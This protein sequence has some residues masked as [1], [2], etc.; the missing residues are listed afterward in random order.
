MRLFPKDVSLA[1]LRIT[2]L[3]AGACT[4][5]CGGGGTGPVA[6]PPPPPPSISVTVSPGTASVLL[7]LTQ[8]FTASVSGTTNTAVTWSVNNVP[9]GG[10]ATGTINSQGLYVAPPSVPAPAT[11]AVSATSQADTT[12]SASAQTT[13]HSDISVTVAPPVSNVELGA[14]QKFTASVS[15]AGQPDV[16]VRWSLSGAS[17]PASC[18]SIDSSGTYTAPQNLPNPSEISIVA[19]SAADPSKQSSAIVHFTSTFTLTLSGPAN[20]LTGGSAQITAT[21]IPVPGSSPNPA[22]TWDLSGAGCSG[23]ACGTLSPSGSSSSSGGTFSTSASYIAP[24]IAPNPASVTITA[25]SA[26]DSSKRA[27]LTIS[28]SQVISVT[29]SPSSA[30]RAANHRLTLFV[31]VTGS[32]NISVAWSVNGVPGGNASVGQICAVGSSPCQSITTSSVSQVDYLAPG[33]IPL[34]NPVMVQAVSQAAPA[35]IGF[36]QITVISHIVVSVTPSAVTLPPS[37]TQPFAAAV[38]GTDDQNAIWQIQ[39]P[40]CAN[41]PCGSVDASGLYAAPLAAPSPNSIQV[42]ATSSEDTSQTGSASVAIAGG[43]N[44]SNLLPASVFA[45][46]ASGFTLKVEGSGFTP[47]SPGPGSTLLIGNAARTTTCSSSS[48]C[49]AP[50]NASDV[51]TA[52]TLS[53]QARNP[54]NSTSN[55]VSLVI[56]APFASDETIS[57][58]SSSPSATD[59]DILVVQPTTAGVSTPGASVDLDVAALGPFSASTNSCTLAGNPVVLARPSSG[60][61]TADLCVFSSS[62]LDTSMNYVLSGSGDVSVISRQPAGLGIIHLILQIASTAVPGPRTLFIENANKDKAAAT[63]ALEV[64]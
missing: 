5:G 55:Q 8:Q 27:A 36:S 39:G 12:K 54:D 64:Q 32:A 48:E 17:C 44:I 57:L 11:V 7:G 56:V 59:R 25:T 14:T 3:T 50:I 29:V 24:A 49:D 22:L 42:V 40:A 19:T 37:A 1:S 26:A 62:G 43:P 63:G 30:T 51:A 47:S 60:S 18:G 28:L 2:L 38:L 46:A 31:Q 53:V 16:S 61:T 15:S 13:I 4:L 20:L 35:Q 45:G 34:A 41:Q 33:A 52:G 6:P 23:S 21:L 10:A 9:G 58:T